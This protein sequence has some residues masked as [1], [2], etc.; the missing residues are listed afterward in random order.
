MGAFVAGMLVLVSTV[1]ISAVAALGADGQDPAN[2]AGEHSPTSRAH[3]AA[4][5]LSGTASNKTRDGAATLHCS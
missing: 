2:G 1:Q 3:L 4:A 5:P